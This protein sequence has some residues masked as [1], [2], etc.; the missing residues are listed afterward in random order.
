MTKR[1]LS[2][3]GLVVLLCLV[4]IAARQSSVRPRREIPSATEATSGAYR[5]GLFLG[6]FAARRGDDFHMAVGRWA[7]EAD[8]QAFDEGYHQGY[9]AALADRK[10]QPAGVR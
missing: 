2:L 6:S 9:N 7:R 5:D 3:F 8:R 4:T 1:K 10:A